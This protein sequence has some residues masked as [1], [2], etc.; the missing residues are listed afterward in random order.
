MNGI[1]EFISWV[2]VVILAAAFL[3]SLARK[4]GIIEWLQVHAPT[5]FL[6][7][8]FSCKFCTSFWTGVAISLTLWM[9]TGAWQ[10]LLIPICSTVIVRDLW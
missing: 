10:M 5:D 9:V 3:L 6:Y 7:K 2:A 4:W 8:L 1:V